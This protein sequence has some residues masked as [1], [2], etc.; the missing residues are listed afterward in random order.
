[1]PDVTPTPSHALLRNPQSFAALRR[2]DALVTPSAFLRDAIAARVGAGP[3]F[4]VIPDAVEPV[5]EADFATRLWNARAFSA[6]GRLRRA[7]AA[8]GLPGMPFTRGAWAAYPALARGHETK[9]MAFA[10]VRVSM[11][12]PRFWWSSISAAHPIIRPKRKAV[13]AAFSNCFSVNDPST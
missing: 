4:E 12:R 8:G 6:L 13:K 2:L 9:V 11:L 10:G 5:P 1:M 7:V 3:R